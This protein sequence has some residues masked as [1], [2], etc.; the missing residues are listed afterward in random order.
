MAV[1]WL[2]TRQVW[3]LYGFS[4]VSMQLLNVRKKAVRQHS[5]KPGLVTKFLRVSFPS[6][7]KS[8][9]HLMKNDLGINT[10]AAGG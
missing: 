4:K 7:A 2:E 5:V 1:Y 9:V 10:F 3:P 6:F 8:A